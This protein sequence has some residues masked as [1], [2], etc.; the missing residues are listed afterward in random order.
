MKTKKISI[1]DLNPRYFKDSN[2]DGI[3]DFK[4]LVQKVD[5]FKFLGV[6]A[7]IIQDIFPSLSK[8][9]K[10][11]YTT[12]DPVLGTIDD[13]RDFIE[14]ITKLNI[15]VF[16]EINIGTIPSN[17]TWFIDSEEKGVDEK[18]SYIEFKKIKKKHMNDETMGYSDKAKGFYDLDT[19]TREV[20]LNWRSETVLEGFVS[21]IE[22]WIKNGVSGFVLKNFER[23]ATNKKFKDS[24]LMNIETCKE[25]FKLYK[26]IKEIDKE[27][28]VIGKS[29][30]IPLQEVNEYT[31]GDRRV[32]DYFQS[33]R[34]SLMNTFNRHGT[35]RAAKFSIKKLVHGMHEFSHDNSHIFTF[36]TEKIGRFISRWGD[37]YQYHIESAKAFA[38]ILMLTPASNSIYFGDE[39]GKRNLGLTHLDDFQDPDLEYRRELQRKHKLTIKA[40]MDAQV[41][42]NPINVKS[43]LAWDETKNGGFTDSKNIIAPIGTHYL[44]DNVK[45]QFADKNSILN[46]YRE[47][48]KLIHKSAFRE[49]L[50][51]GIW[52]ISTMDS[53]FGLVKMKTTL[54]NHKIIIFVNLTDSERRVVTMPKTGKV[55]ISSYDDEY[56]EMP[57]RLRAY[58][59]IVIVDDADSVDH[60]EDVKDTI[61][62]TKKVTAQD[63]GNGEAIKSTDKLDEF[64]E[65]IR[66]QIKEAKQAR[67]EE[68]LEREAKLA[69]GKE[70]F[71]HMSQEVHVS[72][73][74]TL[75]EDDIAAT[76]QLDVDTIEDLESFLE[77]N[78]DEDK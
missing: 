36:G 42:Q 49:I 60:M 30:L 46:F 77:N 39:L 16:L 32:F 35:D 27:V 33:Q 51:N 76:T 20:P 10:N 52:K 62:A 58:E 45:V 41:L 8:E 65:S 44:E 40:F 38:I 15:K 43:P 18:T 56:K 70:Q 9:L 50:R 61:G 6:D 64:K 5:Y 22:F 47:L 63:Y 23:L 74:T 14:K 19:R 59:G 7:L 1:Y 54:D 31:K 69:E 2:S 67:E 25:L 57:K 13:F 48:H 68:R 29:D 71:S 75:T 4:G 34:F 21:V 53:V 55:L 11:N 66:S 12:I 73:H 24:E 72:E 3:G 26:A 17:H 37:D 78:L 28:L